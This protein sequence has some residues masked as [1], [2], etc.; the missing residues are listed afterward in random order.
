M[1]SQRISIITLA[2]Q[3][4]WNIQT[5]IEFNAFL[6]CA[7]YLPRDS[8]IVVLF[9]VLM[10]PHLKG[11]FLSILL[12]ATAVDANSSLFPLAFAVVDAENN[13]NWSWFMDHLHAVVEQNAPAHLIPYFM[14]FLSDCQKGLLEAVQ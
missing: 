6:S 2:A 11:R 13:V 7:L 4:S 12:T 10:D 3:F 14:T 1:E 8:P 5:I 9:W